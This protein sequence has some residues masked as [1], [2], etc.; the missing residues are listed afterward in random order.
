L[1]ARQVGD[2]GASVR[3]VIWKTALDGPW[4]LQRIV[5]WILSSRVSAEASSISLEVV[6][7][8]RLWFARKCLE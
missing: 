2:E 1:G 8:T 5:K 6:V 7:V 3:S 4:G